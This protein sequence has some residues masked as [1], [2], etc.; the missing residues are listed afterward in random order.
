[1][2]V[3][4]VELEITKLPSFKKVWIRIC[5][6]CQSLDKTGFVVTAVKQLDVISKKVSKHLTKCYSE[7]K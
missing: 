5:V 1:M 6:Y 7:R 4:N 3:L 2:A